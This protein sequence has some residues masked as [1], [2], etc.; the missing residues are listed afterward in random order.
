MAGQGDTGAAEKSP[1]PFPV[2]EFLC[3]GGGVGRRGRHALDLGAYT[4]VGEGARAPVGSLPRY[5][6]GLPRGRGCRPRGWAST[7]A[8][9]ELFCPTHIWAC[10]NT[11]PAEG[12][13]R[14]GDGGGTERAV[15]AP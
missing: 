8:R 4:R 9:A 13:H 11:T 3:R 1:R 10:R 12:G 7:G 14:Q 5:R 15:G 6:G 2:G